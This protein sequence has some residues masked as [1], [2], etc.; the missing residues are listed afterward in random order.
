MN[1][2][3][4]EVS[5]EQNNI[6]DETAMNEET[7]IEMEEEKENDGLTK[8]NSRGFIFKVFEWILEGAMKWIDTDYA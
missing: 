3:G 6:F 5:E 8:Y 2:D 1:G 4:N 7:E